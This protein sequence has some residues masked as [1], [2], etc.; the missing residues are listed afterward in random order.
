VAAVSALGYIGFLVGPPMIG[1]LGEAIGLT[2]ALVVVCGLL[3]LAAALAG[4]LSTRART[5]A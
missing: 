5:P 2:E 3:A 1:L 4:H